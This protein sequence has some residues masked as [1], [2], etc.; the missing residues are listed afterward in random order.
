MKKVKVNDFKKANPL[1]ACWGCE[2]STGWTAGGGFKCPKY[3]D[4]QKTYTIR[5]FGTCQFNQPEE[6]LSAKD[7][8]KVR[9]GQQKTKR[10]GR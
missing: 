3:K 7:Q 2:H 5:A 6:V 1:F 4:P 10:K 8:Q 9:V